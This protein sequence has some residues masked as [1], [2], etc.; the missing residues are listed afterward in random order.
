MPVGPANGESR[1]SILFVALHDSPHTARW[2]SALDGQGWDLH[3]FP[4]SSSAVLPDLHGVRVHRPLRRV[5]PRGA[6]GIEHPVLGLPIP[7]RL[8]ALLG[9]VALRI[10]ESDEGA[11]LF[12]GARMLVRL[13]RQLKP[14]LIHS[15]EFQHCGYRVLRARELIGTGFPPWLATNWGSDIYHYQHDLRHRAQI[16][17]LLRAVDFYSCE[18]ERD[19]QLART[20]GLTGQVLPVL[21]NSGGFDLRTAA[22]MRGVSPSR[23]RVI[24]VKGYQHFAGRALTALAALESCADVVANYEVVIFSAAPAVVARASVLR[25]STAIRSIT[26]LPRVDHE[27][28]LRIHAQARVYLGVSASDAISTSVLEAMAM[29]A[30]P[31]QTDTSCADEWFADGVGGYLIPPDDVERI[32]TRLRKALT[33]DALV[34]RAA[35]V[36]WE[37]VK[38]RL[39][40]RLVQQLILAFYRECFESLPRV[41]RNAPTCS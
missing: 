1:P 4:A 26:I 14:D 9:H 32:A 40:K 34:D 24:A 33:D 30:F 25:T 8:E 35:A 28:M 18:C 36:N 37:V 2:I 38:T 22:A 17:R 5:G 39:D 13:I 20:L 27:Q 29:G 6:A 41:G 16:S 21:P 11:P 31:I 15:M 12:Y 7:A 3:L 10:G 23:R 19:V